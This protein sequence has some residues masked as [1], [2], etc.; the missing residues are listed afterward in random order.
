MKF[1]LKN[2]DVLEIKQ[3]GDLVKDVDKADLDSNYFL[4]ALGLRSVGEQY[5]AQRDFGTKNRFHVPPLRPNAFVVV[6]DAGDNG[7]GLIRI[8]VSA[9]HGFSTGNTVYID[10][11]TGTVEANGT[12]VIT[13]IDNYNFDLVGSAYVHAY[14]SAG[15]ASTTPISI[16]NGHTFYDKETQTE[17]EI[18]VGLDS[19]SNTRVYIYDTGSTEASRWIELTRS[20]GALVNDTIGASDSNFDYDTLTEAGVAFTASADFFNN[21]IVVNITQSNETVFITDSTAT[22]LTVDT[23]VGSSGL[24]WANNDVINIYRFPAIKFNY[25]YDNGATPSFDWMPVEQQGKV[26]MLYTNS[27][28]PKVARQPIQIMKKAARSYFYDASGSAYIRTIPAGWY[29]ESDFGILNP[30]FSASGSIASPNNGFTY[31]AYVGAINSSTNATPIVI[32]TNP[33]TLHATSQMV[34][35]VGATPT[36]GS[37]GFWTLTKNDTTHFQLDKSVGSAVGGAL[38]KMVSAAES[39][40]YDKTSGR[41]WLSIYIGASQ[42]SASTDTRK[43]MRFYVTLLFSGGMESDPV[44]Q[45]FFRSNSSPLDIWFAYGVCFALMN[46]NVEAI[47]LYA[48]INPSALEP[49]DW[50]DSQSEYVLISSLRI[51]TLT[52]TT[53]QLWKQQN[54]AYREKSYFGYF[55]STY[56]HLAG[57]DVQNAIDGGQIN[58]NDAL[59]HAVD[60]N[61]SYPTPTF[62][63][64]GT[65]EQG[66]I[67]A[68]NEGNTKLHLSLYDGYGVHQDDN[69]PDVA[70]DNNGNK[71]LIEMFGN[72]E[73]LG[74]EILYDTIFAF[75]SN[76][77]ETFDLQGVAKRTYLAD[78]V[79]A[80]S[81]VATPYGVVFAGKAA[82]YLIPSDGGEI[83]VLNELWNNYYGGNEYVTGSTQY[84]TDAYRSAIISGYDDTYREANVLIQVNT[85]TSSEY[86]LHRF[87]FEDQK[88]KQRKL[89]TTDLIKYFTKRQNDGTFTIGLSKGLLKYP[90]RIGS[91]QWE[92]DV[93]VDYPGNEISQSKAVPFTFTLN[94][95]RFNNQIL[96]NVL[97]GFIVNLA[98][99]STGSWGLMK[100]EFFAN[101]ETV[102]FDTQYL[103]VDQKMDYRMIERRGNIENLKIKFTM[104]DSSI[105]KKFDVSKITLGFISGTKLGNL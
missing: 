10:E 76:L 59:N 28:T 4:E 55:S 51:Q 50:T 1:G 52:D 96:E 47:N 67:V 95:A 103:R 70:V 101:R 18:I 3:T 62:A 25:T 34:V 66:S 82:I 98:G 94:I 104:P 16:I 77:I 24:G 81:I 21:W 74:L 22:N 45:G 75:R 20:F 41:N 17:Y 65:R 84:I 29:V 13:K 48:A 54:L 72:S 5:V 44:Y 63:T 30:Y 100:V 53:N 56:N 58:L 88:W 12:W 80:R 40:I 99:E 91:Y 14:V 36:A 7:S 33:A 86:I 46:K 42:N 39:E 83:R 15:I 26:A 71:M 38:G 23:V 27:A 11:V 93:R 32:E 64:K 35:V 69:F 19:S 9:G 87:S 79:S 73:L 31:A 8:N 89:N 68:I 2:L 85:A 78:I 92:D 37:N 102:A 6:T 60:K 105:F 43:Q 97:H 57:L 61:R 49:T 90:N